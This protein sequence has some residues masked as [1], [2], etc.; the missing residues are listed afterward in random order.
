MEPI[1]NNSLRDGERE[2]KAPAMETLVPL[3]FV[4]GTKRAHATASIF[5]NPRARWALPRALLKTN[6]KGVNFISIQ[7]HRR[8]RQLSTAVRVRLLD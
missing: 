6:T 2:I 4:L 3:E 7:Q 5:E 1:A 8:A